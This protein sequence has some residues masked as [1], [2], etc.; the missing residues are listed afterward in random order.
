MK[1]ISS[2]GLSVCP[3]QSELMAGQ[4]STGGGGIQAQPSP[5]VVRRRNLPVGPYGVG[6]VLLSVHADFR[7]TSLI[8]LCQ[9]GPVALNF[10][11]IS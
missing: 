2:R 8:R 6:Q 10:A 1:I 5:I 4:D 3:E 11:T 9:P 7:N